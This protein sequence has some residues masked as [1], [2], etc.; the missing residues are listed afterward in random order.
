[1]HWSEHKNV[2]PSITFLKWLLSLCLAYQGAVIT[3][4]V[5]DQPTLVLPEPGKGMT[6][7]SQSLERHDMAQWDLFGKADAA[8]VAQ[9]EE[10]NAPKTRLRLVLMGVFMSANKADS[11]AIIAEQGREGEF[12]KVG[13]RVQGRARLSQVYNDK[14]IL[15]N[16]GKLET[17]TFADAEKLLKGIKAN[18]RKQRP[19]PKKNSAGLSKKNKG[20]FKRQLRGIRTPEKFVDFA[21]QQLEDPVQAMENLGLRAVGNGYL[22]TPSATMLMSLGMKAGDKLISIN[23]YPLGDPVQDKT[24]IDEV[25][26]TG[27]A[28]IVIER[29]SRRM[30]INHSF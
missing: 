7:S 27:N 30:T 2:E 18:E 19:T 15:D 20:D 28:S 29:G 22:L 9:E 16:S 8:P 6:A 12:F 4:M 5:I 17:L 24:I 23:G 11:S 26:E 21:K 14:V 1:V 10:I 13:A 25:Y 3:W